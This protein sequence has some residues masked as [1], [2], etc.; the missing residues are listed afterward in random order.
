M[1]DSQGILAPLDETLKASRMEPK[2][3]PQHIREQ[4]EG[5]LS[6]FTEDFFL[7]QIFYARRL[8]RFWPKTITDGRRI[9]KRMG[10]KLSRGSL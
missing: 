9:V 2:T 5:S 10:C 7:S 1:S 4:M 6:S 3:S 8:A